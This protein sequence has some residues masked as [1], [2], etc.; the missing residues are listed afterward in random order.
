MKYKGI[1][2]PSPAKGQDFTKEVDIVVP[3]QTM[4]LDY[5]IRKFTRG[6]ALPPIAQSVQFG[7]ETDLSSVE[8]DFEK[9][10]NLDLVDKT[11]F[12]EKVNDLIS[13]IE[14]RKAAIDAK[15]KSEQAQDAKR[16]DEKRIRLA[17]RKLAAKQN[18]V[19]LA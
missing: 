17:A 11:E 12:A 4:S 2:L 1:A 9:F 8:M 6:E 15:L 5:I 19:R 14:K 7:S 18:A 13:K 16:L 3:D 10:K